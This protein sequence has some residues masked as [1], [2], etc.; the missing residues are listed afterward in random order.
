MV[1]GIQPVLLVF[2]FGKLIVS[3]NLKPLFHS[4]A[5]SIQNFALIIFVT[6]SIATLHDMIGIDELGDLPIGV[7]NCFSCF[8]I[9]VMAEAND[10]SVSNPSRNHTFE[11]FQFHVFS[12]HF[13]I[14]LRSPLSLYQNLKIDNLLVCE[15][16][17]SH[18]TIPSLWAMTPTRVKKN[19]S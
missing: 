17:N 8:R 19:D 6:V 18:G 12:R 9:V 10:A 4:F 13:V 1:D 7:V 14:R 16:N 3:K 2:L 11:T 15:T 5:Q